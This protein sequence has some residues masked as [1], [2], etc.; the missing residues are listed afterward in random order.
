[1]PGRD[2]YKLPNLVSMMRI[3]L[4]PLLFILALE[5]QP[6]WFLIVLIVTV[7]TDVLDGYLARTL[8]QITELG[9][10]LDSW[11][12]FIVY[13]VMTVSAVLLWPDIVVREQV[14]FIIILSSFTIPVLIGLVKFKTVTSY[15]TWSVKAAVA[16]TIISYILL[17]SG[18]LDWPFKLAAAVCLYAA[19]EEIC[20][21]LI[22][23]HEHVDVKTVWHAY[24]INQQDGA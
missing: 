3:F 24:K 11:G 18:W 23:K 13:S 16:T 4:A 22:M 21:S 9:S 7:F 17:F 12:D 2:I 19:I 14:Y 5:Q 8:N 1:M 10:H 20:I 6:G 15:H